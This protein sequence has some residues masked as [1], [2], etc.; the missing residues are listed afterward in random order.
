M[1]KLYGRHAWTGQLY[2]VQAYMNAL[3]Q[4]FK[5]KMISTLHGGIACY[6]STVACMFLYLNSLVRCLLNFSLPA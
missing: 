4:N 5:I 1:I 6:Y 3:I 2:V